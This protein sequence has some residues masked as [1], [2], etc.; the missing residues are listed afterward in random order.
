MH[1]D[2]DSLQPPGEET[3]MTA[4]DASPVAR[5]SD[6][7]QEIADLVQF[8]AIMGCCDDAIFA[9]DAVSGRIVDASGSA[10]RR[11]G[12]D[13]D[14]LLS[15]DIGD[16]LDDSARD[17]LGSLR[18]GQA[19]RVDCVAALRG[20]DGIDVPCEIVFSA[21]R[22][23]GRLIAVA[24]ARDLSERRREESRLRA[25]LHEK[26][27][28]LK[29]VH[30]RVKNNLQ[31]V[32][33]LLN[34]QTRYLA[35]PRDVDLFRESQDRVR[36]M[37]LVHE[38]LYQ[39]EHMAD[40]DFQSY[41]D[42]LVTN[43]FRSYGGGSGNIALRMDLKEARL[44]VDTAIPCGLIVNELVT[45]ALKYAFPDGRRGVI[46]ISFRPEGDQ[47]VLEVGDDGV[48]LPE[49]YRADGSK[50]LGLLLVT[51]LVSQLDGT[52]DIDTSAG[53]RFTIRFRKPVPK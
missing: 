30:H 15:L 3:R 21:A 8:R 35:D 13:R 18:A 28:M 37:A 47:Y 48:G 16:I 26:E 17:A 19:S 44:N 1:F 23:E 43:L 42:R 33:S 32:S 45:N 20:G 6:L 9:F 14:A 2:R 25:S 12:R 4:E 5:L 38:K 46:S 31:V 52:L 29:E 7:Q 39:S 53:T 24:V 50:S 36:S 40:I 49:G 11:L 41:T 10:C 34:I 51:S 27:V 22:L